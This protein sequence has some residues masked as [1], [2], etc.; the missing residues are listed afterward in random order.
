MVGVASAPVSAKVYL[1]S[2]TIHS[3][4]CPLGGPTTDIFTDCH[5][6]PA[7][8]EAFR[9]NLH[10]SQ[11]VNSSG[12]TTFS[13]LGS[14]TRTVWLSIGDQ[15]N[16]FLHERVFC[17]ADGAPAHELAISTSGGLAHFSF[18]LGGSS[19]V[20]CDYYFIPESGA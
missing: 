5:P 3:R 14:G 12:N 18:W 8:D 6:H 1:S 16:E 20:T 4:L 9:V 2:I 13:G 19:N 17:S 11:W 15:P 7:T 10:S